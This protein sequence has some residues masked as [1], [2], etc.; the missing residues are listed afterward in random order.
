[1]FLHC[2]GI[3]AVYVSI[4]WHNL[5][6]HCIGYAYID[7]HCYFCLLELFLSWFAKNVSSHI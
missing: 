5:A 2:S 7:E 3:L 1:M 4:I 6:T